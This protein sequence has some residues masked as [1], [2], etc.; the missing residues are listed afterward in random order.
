M[1]R[2]TAPGERGINGGV[3]DVPGRL[4]GGDPPA[5]VNGHIDSSCTQPA[6]ELLIEFA[7]AS[8]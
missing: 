7:D 6:Q 4:L 3:A 5:E 1:G 8:L 2:C